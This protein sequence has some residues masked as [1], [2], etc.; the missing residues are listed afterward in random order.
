[1]RVYRRGELTRAAALGCGLGG[2]VHHIGVPVEDL[3]VNVV[4]V[5]KLQAC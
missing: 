5:A 2:D 4:G 3:D 1:M